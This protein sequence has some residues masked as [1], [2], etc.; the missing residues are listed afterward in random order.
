MLK[1]TATAEN[2]F[3]L[4]VVLPAQQREAF[5]TAQCRAMPSNASI[6]Q[7]SKKNS[8]ISFG[9]TTKTKPP[10]SFSTARYL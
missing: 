4:A 8:A 7:R 2:L 9:R 10:S 3:A 1:K 5:I 6:T